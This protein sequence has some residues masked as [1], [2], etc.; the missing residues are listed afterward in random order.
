MITK[1]NN[2]HIRLTGKDANDFLRVLRGDD[3]VELFN[4][5]YKIGDLVQVKGD[6]GEIFIDKVRF[7]ASVMGGHT[8]MAWLEGK[9]SYLI[10]RVIGKAEE[11]KS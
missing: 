7:P 11:V 6:N 9:G 5:K 1:H 3:K 10:D 2:G 4:L 8:A